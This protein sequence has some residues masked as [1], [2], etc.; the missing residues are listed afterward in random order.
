MAEDVQLY[1]TLGS[2]PKD[3]MMQHPGKGGTGK[4]VEHL[5]IPGSNICAA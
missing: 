3:G 5:V 2:S 1:A 4:G